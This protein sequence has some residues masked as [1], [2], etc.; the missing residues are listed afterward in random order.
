MNRWIIGSA[1]VSCAAAQSHAAFTFGDIE[2]WV[3]SGDHAAALV[4]DWNDGPDPVSL[5]W[6]FRWDGV[7]TGADM[8]FAVIAADS[9]LYGRFEQFAFGPAI[10]GLGYDL[11]GDGFSIS[12][13]TTFDA[14]GFSFAGRSDGATADD[15]GDHYAEGW[16][17][18]FWSY[19]LG[20][21]PF[22]GGTWEGAFV[23]MNDRV[24]GDGDWDGLRFAPEFVGEPPRLPVA[25]VPAPMSAA[26]LAVG[27]L[28]SGRRR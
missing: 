14:D 28:A 11:D 7:A 4:I 22:A 9:N 8:L 5:A 12:D 13:G 25:A 15:P 19:W 27:L 2:F 17:T 3:G 6:G 18:G 10:I 1:L 24:L 23:G 20:N 16:N 21:E 26:L